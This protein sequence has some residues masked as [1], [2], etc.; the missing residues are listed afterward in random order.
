[1]TDL[2]GERSGNV[3]DHTITKSFMFFIHSSSQW[4]TSVQYFEVTGGG[5]NI[6]WHFIQ[7]GENGVSTEI[8][9]CISRTTRRPTYSMSARARG[10]AWHPPHFH[11]LLPQWLES[12][13]LLENLWDVRLHSPWRVTEDCVRERRALR[14]LLPPGQ[15]WG[16]KPWPAEGTFSQPG[17]HTAVSLW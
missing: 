5:P 14:E 9:T 1:M 8:N 4:F 7:E 11:W 2:G 12:P 17:Q 13:G 6:E 16:Q 10:C 3:I 15:P